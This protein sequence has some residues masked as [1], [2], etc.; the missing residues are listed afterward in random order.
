MARLGP[1]HSDKTPKTPVRSPRP[2]LLHLED[3]STPSTLSGTIF[4]DENSNLVQDAGEPG[5][6]NVSVT[7]ANSATG[8]ASS[9]MTT[10]DANGNF[11]FANL[12]DGTYTVTVV[13]TPSTTP[14]GPTTRTV[15][16]AGQDVSGINLGLLPNGK[17]T[18][19]AYADL[20]GNGS[21]DPTEPGIA[22][23]AVSLT[24][25]NGTVV[26]TTTTA[27]DGTFSFSGLPDG[28]YHVSFAAPVNYTPTSTAAMS[29]TIQGGNTETGENLGFKPSTSITGVVN[30][31]GAT[32][33]TPVAGA[34]VTLELNGSTSNELTTTTN[35]TGTYYFANVPTGTDTVSVAAQQ[36]TTF[37][38]ADGSNSQSVTVAANS[39]GTANFT[40]SYPGWV[41]G[42]LFND[43]NGNGVQDPGEVNITPVRVQVDLFGNG[44]LQ[45][46]T[47]RIMGDGSFTIAGL[48]DGTHEIVITPPSGYT[49]T[50]QTRET[51]T[52]KNGSAATITPIG[53]RIAPGAQVAIGSGT[54][55]GAVV[56]N[57]TTDTSGGL[58]ETSGL[59]V[60]PTGSATGTR[61]LMADV[62]GDGIPD[63]VTAT[64]PGE[65][66]MIHVYDGKTGAELVPGGIQVFENG[67]SGGLNIA[68]GDFNGDGKADIVVAADTG[69]GPRIQ[70]LN[71]SAFLPGAAAGTPK[72]LADFMG[73]ADPSFRGGTR[74]A[75][76]DLNG[77]GTP[78]L[79]VAAGTGGGPRVA[80]FDGT[81]LTPGSTPKRLV[82]DFFA[83]ESSLRN[84]AV[85][86][87]GDING[88]GHADLIAAAGPGGAPRVEVFDGTGILANQGA[89]ASQ[90]A[91]FFVNN[92]TTSRNG[93]QITVKDV[94]GDGKGDI[95][96][97]SGG[98]VYVYTG[99]NLAANPTDPDVNVT[100]APFGG[101]SSLNVG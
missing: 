62:N 8:A 10:T 61:V 81:S 97:S 5:L 78:D 71:I 66:A 101:A 64:G 67:F 38:T 43:L 3:R 46:V 31:N 68:A 15:T 1:R 40:L 99:K 52:I 83:F 7:L 58:T 100:L 74:V 94:D 63:L 13:P 91:D 73:I 11:S 69:G 9:I 2:E 56:Y 19:T 54:G 70:I 29:V 51:F 48:S 32:T 18:G 44:V 57:F 84:G 79:V 27:A 37:N 55:S 77:D 95:V 41:S 49:A 86:A 21:L 26:S 42:S 87:V 60:A 14:V 39:T 24:Q 28:V 50:T 89:N 35:S 53:I 6:A 12:P 47:P 96:V 85:V 72:V 33:L 45:D 59:S 82:A 76:G 92:D 36:G 34:V 22:G 20:N 23:I 80:I 25:P 88:D 90:L 4:A 75:V 17:I 30:A 16:I 65:T 98:T 93:T